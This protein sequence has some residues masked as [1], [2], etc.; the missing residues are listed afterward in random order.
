MLYYGDN[1]V[2]GCAAEMTQEKCHL[3]DKLYKLQYQSCLSRQKKQMY[4]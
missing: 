2:L 1:G 3:V 4:C